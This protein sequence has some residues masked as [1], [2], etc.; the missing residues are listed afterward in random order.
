MDTAF[1]AARKKAMDEIYIITKEDMAT[2]MRPF[3]KQ[4]SLLRQE[5]CT[6]DK[7]SI[8]HE[9]TGDIRNLYSPY[10]ELMM[11]EAKM[12][13]GLSTG[14]KERLVMFEKQK[15][16]KDRVQGKYGKYGCRLTMKA[17]ELLY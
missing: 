3:E 13:K 4:I 12:Q 6:H 16:F 8:Y 10:R 14:L 1:M 7:K 9:I 2:L 17:L 11:T 15:L 5:K